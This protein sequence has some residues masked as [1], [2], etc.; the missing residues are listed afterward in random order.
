MIDNLSNGVGLEIARTIR[1]ASLTRNNP[2]A[3][4]FREVEK[5]IS[6]ASTAMTEGFNSTVDK[7]NLIATLTESALSLSG[8][9]VSE[10]KKNKNFKKKLR[11]Q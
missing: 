6:E 3:K 4:A 8:L 1:E 5:K 9:R 11:Q 10:D 7:D 2:N